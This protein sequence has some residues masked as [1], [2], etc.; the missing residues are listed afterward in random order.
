MKKL[1]LSVSIGL[2][3]FA[4]CSTENVDTQVEQQKDEFVNVHL[5]DGDNLV[6]ESFST[7]EMKIKQS[8][9]VIATNNANKGNSVHA[10]G[11]FHGFGGTISFSGTQNNGGV[12]GSA[13]IEISSGGGPFGPGGTAHI[14]LDTASVVIGNVA[15]EDGALYGGMVT[16]VIEN[17]IPSPPNGC[18]YNV[19]A[20]I[21]FFVKDNGQGNNAPVDQFRS[22][23]ISSCNEPT[24]ASVNSLINFLNFPFFSWN[25]V[26]EAS[27]KIKVNY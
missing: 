15:G 20:Y 24:E 23:I 18:G 5:Y 2:L 12:H 3:L 13:E 7:D 6:W 21:S 25:D 22:A 10:H 14:I 27:D 1:I 9:L 8:N 19:G 17:T 4:G 16:E 11:D 26:G